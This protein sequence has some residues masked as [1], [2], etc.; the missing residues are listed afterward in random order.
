MRDTGSKE[1]D[2]LLNERVATSPLALRWMRG[3]PRTECAWRTTPYMWCEQAIIEWSRRVNSIIACCH[4]VKFCAH[5]ARAFQS[6]Q[7]V[8]VTRMWRSCLHKKNVGSVRFV[9]KKRGC[10]CNLSAGVAL[11]ARFTTNEMCAKNTL[12]MWRE[13]AIIEWSWWVTWTVDWTC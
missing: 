11:N 12:Y 2:C 1:K 10:R 5:A 3:S 8:A 9:V 13:Q 6:Q 4:S 7:N